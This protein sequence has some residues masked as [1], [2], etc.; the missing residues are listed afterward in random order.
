MQLLT[1]E[2]RNY[3]FDISVSES[4]ASQWLQGSLVTFIKC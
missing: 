2:G 4:V 3:L 1:G